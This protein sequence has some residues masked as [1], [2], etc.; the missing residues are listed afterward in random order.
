MAGWSVPVF[1]GLAPRAEPRLL[2]ENQAQ[3]A[4]NCKLW[5]GSLRPLAENLQVLANF[6]KP[7]TIQTIYRF[8]K[9]VESDITYW[10]HWDS[11][12]DVCRG[13][14]FDDT[15]E[16]TY[17]TDGTL[18]KV[19]DSSIALTGGNSYPMNAYT[20]GVPAPTACTASVT[21]NGTG[22]EET[23]V[24][25]YTYVSSFGE[26]GKPAPPA[27]E[28][29][30]KA[31]QSVDLTSLAQAPTLNSNLTTK[32]I[33]RT[34][35][36]GTDTNYY[37]VDE[38]PISQVTY[39]D[40]ILA[41]NLGETLPSAT[42]SMPPATMRGLISM[43]N[44]MMA[45]FDGKE[46][47]LCEPYKPYAWPIAYRQTTDYDIVAL[48]A[49]DTT[50]VV[51]TNGF[52]Y[53]LQGSSPDATAMVKVNEPQ[54]CV[55]KRSVRT[56]LGAVVY[57]SPDGLYAIGSGGPPVNLTEATF[58]NKEWRSWFRPSSIHAY[59][60]D[61][62]YIGFYD[63]GTAQGG[64]ILDTKK[65]DFTLLDWHATAGYYDPQRDALFLV[66][67]GALVKFDEATSYC[68]A[69]WRSK[70]FYS[71]RPINIGAI[72]VDATSYPVSVRIYADG[73]HRGTF[74]ISSASPQRLPDGYTAHTYE[75]EVHTATEVMRVD[76]AQT[77][78]ELVGG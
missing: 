71:P 22:L 47:Y 31:G 50:L 37:F 48:G 41:E 19:T 43:A 67:N 54:T 32:R 18:P 8:G 14:V 21:G 35:T 57:A 33:Y 9:E 62:K 59:V 16:R 72:R 5:H 10:F 44:G 45:G 52:P 1:R 11:D 2:Q 12:V 27:T 68:T 64:F 23:R 42:Y 61:D 34:V 46:V 49:L 6:P 55:S 24:Y 15:T 36:S 77:I 58:T 39:S 4:I 73:K 74:S 3:V 76:I 65:G 51:L 56:V 20:L 60:Y 26:E 40:T 53:V 30:V 29:N 28:V 38:I 69:I 13:Q 25:T 78:K 63:N 75:F 70:V 17:F 7:G 66:V